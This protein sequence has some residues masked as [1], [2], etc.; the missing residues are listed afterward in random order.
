[1]TGGM[2]NP[3]VVGQSAEPA[4]AARHDDRQIRNEIV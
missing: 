1:M 2:S 3:Q 4:E